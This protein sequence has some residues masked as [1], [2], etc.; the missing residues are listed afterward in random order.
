ME[1]Y[2]HI[3]IVEYN[4]NDAILEIQTIDQIGLVGIVDK[5]AIKLLRGLKTSKQNI[6][7][8]NKSLKQYVL[9]EN[10]VW[11]GEIGHEN[12]RSDRDFIIDLRAGR[13]INITKK[14]KRYNIAKYYNNIDGEE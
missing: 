9:L 3:P 13:H 4:H 7:V 8:Y 1:Y 11:V 5:D 12:V 10:S 14:I 2:K 6:I